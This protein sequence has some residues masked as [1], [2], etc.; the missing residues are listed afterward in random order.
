MKKALGL[1]VVAVLAI[2]VVV[3][4]ARA[5]QDRLVFVDEYLPA[6]E[7]TER[8]ARLYRLLDG[9]GAALRRRGI[10]HWAIGG[11][12]L[13][14]VRHRGMIP[15]DDDIDIALWA[16]DLGRARAAVA[17]DLGGWTTWGR[18]FRSHTVSETARPDVVLDVF[19]AA[20]IGGGDDGAV[21]HFVNPHARAKWPKEYLTLDEFGAPTLAAFGPTQVPVVGKPCSYLDR[22]YPEWDT[23]GRIARHYQVRRASEV[24]AADERTVVRFDRAQSREFCEPSAA[25]L[26]AGLIAAN[27]EN[28]SA[29]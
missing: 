11:T 9:V 2:I 5:G 4:A 10:P 3:A 25:D 7:E 14:A 6:R 13:G 12:M 19:P 15:W 26:I 17:E 23:S 1:A 8:Q 24:P 18:E 28:A 16:T 27:D 21:V 20:V 29:L 22:V